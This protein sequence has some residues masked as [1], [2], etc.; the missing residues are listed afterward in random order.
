MR[1]TVATLIWDANENSLVFSRCYDEIWVE[2]L[3]RGFQRNLTEPFRFVCFTDKAREF[4]P[5]IEQVRLS[6]DK[7]SYSNC[8]EPYALNEPMILVGL[9]TI[10]TGNIDHLAER[11]LSAD[12]IALPRDPF[13]PKRACN[14]VALV[15]AGNAKVYEAWRG[16][17]D[18]EWM[19]QQ[20]HV[21]IDDLFPGHVVSFKGSARDRGLG[22]AR[23]VY[24]HGQ[25][26]PHQLP[27][28]PWIADHWR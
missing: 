10:V 4:P 9:D 26:K 25:E 16:E 14:G 13:S 12:V 11:C 19:R 22:D 20:P 1:L 2:K 23:I 18:M 28:V 27:N 21:F 6:S 15:P 3:Y 5:G 7:P 24:F 17:N 8:I